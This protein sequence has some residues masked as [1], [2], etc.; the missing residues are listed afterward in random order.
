MLG[1]LKILRERELRHICAQ[2]IS[3]LA[4]PGSSYHCICLSSKVHNINREEQ[5]RKTDA[6]W[7]MTR[8]GLTLFLEIHWPLYITQRVQEK[9][10]RCWEKCVNMLTMWRGWCNNVDR[11]E[12]DVE[13]NRSREENRRSHLGTCPSKAYVLLSQSSGSGE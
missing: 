3:R 1:V 11:K 4:L 7:D 10:V 8:K 9:W 6:G 2:D 13:R 12:K 5:E